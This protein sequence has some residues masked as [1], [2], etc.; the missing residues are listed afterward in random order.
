MKT[1]SKM[2]DLAQ[3]IELLKHKQAYDLEILKTHFHY[4]YEGLKPVNL[5]KEI[6]HDLVSS[7]EIKKDLLKG[8]VGYFTNKFFS[9][10]T[11]NPIMRAIDFVLKKVMG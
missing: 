3:K 4:T 1:N 11:N 10:K 2:D 9:E 5:I 7:S 8:A 6:L